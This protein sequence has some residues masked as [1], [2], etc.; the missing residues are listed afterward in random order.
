MIGDVAVEFHGLMKDDLAFLQH[1]AHAVHHGVDL[2]LG[3]I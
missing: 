3:H 1:A 2:P